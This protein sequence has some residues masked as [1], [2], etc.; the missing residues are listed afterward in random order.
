MDAMDKMDVMDVM[1]GTD[2]R[3]EWDSRALQGSR[4]MFVGCYPGLRCAYPGLWG[5]NPFRV[6]GVLALG[7]GCWVYS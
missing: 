6:L 7:V 2:V 5:F 1:D 3:G 4:R